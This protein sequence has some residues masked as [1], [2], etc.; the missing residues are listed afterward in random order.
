MNRDLINRLTAR[1]PEPLTARDWIALVAIAAAIAP[2]AFAALVA[3][4]I[5]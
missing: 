1:Q 5:L 3:A 4:L 2:L